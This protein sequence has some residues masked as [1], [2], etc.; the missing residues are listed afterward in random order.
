MNGLLREKWANGHLPLRR[1][2]DRIP[3]TITSLIGVDRIFE[4]L[5]SNQVICH[6][7]LY[8]RMTAYR[9]KHG[10]E[11]LLGA[12]EGWKLAVDTKQLVYV[13]ST[14]TSK[15]FDCL[16]HSLTIKKLEAYG[17]GS[18]SLDLMLSFFD[19][20]QNRVK[21]GEI[22]SDWQ[23]VKRGCPQ[24]SSFVPLLWNMFQNDLSSYVEDANLV[25]MLTTT[26]SM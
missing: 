21:L 14:D 17:F 7:T 13:L 3:K 8:Y 12:I 4:Q 1:E 25:C 11:T 15:A 24:G 16:S 18:R 26:K 20:R 5:L 6:K 9:K 2:I 19:K 22:T 23:K 10:C